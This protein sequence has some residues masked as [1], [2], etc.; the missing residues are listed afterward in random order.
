M[1]FFSIY[2]ALFLKITWW[3]DQSL[4]LDL[5]MLSWCSNI[6]KQKIRAKGLYADNEELDI[7]LKE[8]DKCGFMREESFKYN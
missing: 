6:F 4:R 2:S 8:K 5:I 3:L 7:H 1:M